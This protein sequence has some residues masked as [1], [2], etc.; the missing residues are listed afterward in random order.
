MP[1][2]WI[3]LSCVVTAAACLRAP[4]ARVPLSPVPSV[5]GGAAAAV[6]RGPAA[7]DTGPRRPETAATAAATT[8]ASVTD[9]D[10]ARETKRVFGEGAPPPVDTA[11]ASSGPVWDIDVHSYETRQRVADYVGIFSG[12]VKEVFEIALQRQ[13]RY[14]PMVRAR[15]KAAG[16]P[17]DLTY[18]ALIESWYNP[19]AYSKAAAVG[20]WQF[21]AGT[22]RGMGLRI[23]WWIDERRDPVRSTDAAARLLAGYR[24]QFGS[25]YLA[26]AAYNGGEGRVTR[27][28]ARHAS[29]LDE[30]EG[31]DIYWGLAGTGYLRKETRDYVP[32]IIAA[33]LVGEEPARYGVHVDSLPPFSYDS[34]QVPGGTPLAAVANALGVDRSEVGELNP[35]ILRG[36][37]PPGET[38]WVRVPSGRAVGFDERFSALEPSEREGLMRME[39]KKGQTMLSIA[40]SH[41]IT[42]RQL[43]WFNPKVAKLK[44]GALRAGQLILVPR[45]DV[46]ALARDVPNPSIERYPRRRASGRRAA[47]ATTASKS[48]KGKSVAAKPTKGSGTSTKSRAAKSSKSGAV[49]KGGA[50]AKSK[51]TKSPASKSSKG[52]SGASKSKTATSTASKP[53]LAH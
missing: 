15:L 50:A 2:T 24:T 38:L 16:L 12:R 18:L 21:M 44:S 46:V 22:G 6:V 45:V 40:K 33:A 19:H 27:G 39:S 10:L 1:R 48:G 23:N 47:T 25:V 31:E 20:F 35:H 28:L 37:T 32:K 26:A 49:A 43:T 14:G 5:P 4:S 34:V 11:S 17:E 42:Q 7:N 36:M 3:V 51:S 52:A 53:K 41:G 30:L 8:G 9:A 13:T 29:V